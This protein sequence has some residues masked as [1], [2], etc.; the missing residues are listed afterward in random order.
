[1][2]IGKVDVWNMALDHIGESEALESAE[3]TAPAA[4]VCAR[5]WER[6]VREALE[7]HAWRWATRVRRLVDVAEQVAQYTGDGTL[8]TYQLPAAYLDEDQIVVTLTS[9]G[10][11]TTLAQGTDYTITAPTEGLDGTVTLDAGNLGVGDVLTITISVERAGWTYTYAAPA[12][13]VTPIA[14]RMVGVRHDAVPA[15][16]R[17]PFALVPNDAGDGFYICTDAATGDMDGLE[18]VAFLDTVAIWPA[19]FVSLVAWGLAAALADP[20]RKDPSV[21][22][23]CEAR[24]SMTLQDAAAV[25]D[26]ARHETETITPTLLERA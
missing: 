18:Y 19:A 1:M 17:I 5:H 12:D 26:S 10:T 20:L 23:R 4:L 21:A 2:A 9:G 3:D 14:I 11:T 13:M 6:V 15:Q 22:M 16:A 8:D 25:D 24:Y 7:L